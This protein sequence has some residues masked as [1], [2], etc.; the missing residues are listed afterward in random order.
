MARPLNPA[1][2]AQERPV[3]WAAF[4]EAA[5]AAGMDPANKWV[6][7]YPAYE[8]DHLRA[9]LGAYGIDVS[10]RKVL[11]FG[12]NV[13]ASSVVLA[14]LGADVV[15]V[16]VDAAHVRIAAAGLKLHEIGSGAKVLHVSD[17][18]ALPFENGAFDFGIANSVLEYVEPDQLEAVM[19]EI[20]RVLAPGATLLVCGTASRLAPREIHS[21]RWLV[22]YC[23][24]ALAP[25]WQRGL[26]PSHLAKAIEGKFVPTARRRWLAARRAVHGKASFPVRV[27]D[28]LARLLGIAPGWLAPNIELLLRKV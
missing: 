4:C 8:W 25:S 11:E 20:H 13:G 24:T 28:R 14:K 23:P 5:Q 9:L 17:T 2:L 1:Q 27:V 26:S 6:G 22:N 3:E 10:G 18:R 16:D 19:A 12:C 7:A 15:G 21:R